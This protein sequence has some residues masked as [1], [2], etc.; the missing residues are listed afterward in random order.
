M[1]TQ[2][3]IFTR[4]LAGSLFAALL[5]LTVSP[6]AS[7]VDEVPVPPPAGAVKVAFGIIGLAHLQTARLN[8]VAIG[9][10]TPD[11]SN[12]CVVNLSFRDATGELFKD[13]RGMPISAEFTIAPGQ[14][15][16]LD[17]REA[18]AFRGRAG[19]RVAFQTSAELLDTRHPPNPCAAIVPTLEIYDSLIGRTALLYPA[20]PAAIGGGTP[21]PSDLPVCPVE[22]GFVD[23]LGEVFRDA[24]GRPIAARFVLAPG[25][26]GELDLRTADAF[27]GSTGLRKA[28]RAVA[29]LAHPPS[30]CRPPAAV[31]TL[32]VFDNVTGRSALLYAPMALE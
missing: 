23:D 8:V 26:A 17:L 15:A 6:A 11:P 3:S 1:R 29:R 2:A 13:G 9:G 4:I 19:L 21:D 14:A 22:V 28:F 18:D 27:R 32:E 5:M 7:A 24:S 12:R 20:D 31:A 16:Q 25:E 30:P 10:G